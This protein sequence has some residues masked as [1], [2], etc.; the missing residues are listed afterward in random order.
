MV[1]T[2]ADKKAGETVQVMRITAQERRYLQKLITFGLLPGATVK[3]IRRQPVLIVAVDNTV[4]ALDSKM[5]GFIQ[6]VD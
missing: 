1:A 2:L 6:V 3:I 4:V 5:A